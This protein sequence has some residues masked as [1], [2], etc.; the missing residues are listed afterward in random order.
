MSDVCAV[1]ANLNCNVTSAELWT[2]NTRVAAVVN[3]TDVSTGIP[4]RDEKHI[5]D[6]KRLLCN[7]LTSGGTD[8]IKSAHTDILFEMTHRE[9]RLHQMMYGGRDFDCAEGGE[10]GCRPH[11]TVSDCLDRGYTVVMLRSKDRAKLLFDTVCTLTDM[12]YVVYHGMV[13]TG[14]KEAYQVNFLF[15]GF[16][17]AVFENYFI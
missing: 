9:R 2:H 4:I 16:G 3:I 6:I 12:Q 11:V 17:N 8:D 15:S 7:V 14:N 10:E 5:S 13:S 1:L